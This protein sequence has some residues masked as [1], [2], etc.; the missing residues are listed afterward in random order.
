MFGE[1]FNGI[2][3]PRSERNPGKN[4]WGE[5]PEPATY[6]YEEKI[7]K[8]ILEEISDK[9]TGGSVEDV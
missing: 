2:D 1:I 4:R 9:L 5:I 3:L 6:Q 7:Y 8:L